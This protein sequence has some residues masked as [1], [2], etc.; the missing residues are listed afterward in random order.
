V[1]EVKPKVVISAATIAWGDCKPTFG[2]NL[3]CKLTCQNWDNWLDDGLLDAN[4]PMNYRSESSGKSSAQFRNWLKGF[5]RWNGGRPTYVG[6]DMHNNSPSGIMRQIAAVRKAGLEGYVLFSF[7][8]FPLRDSMVAALAKRN[9]DQVD[10]FEGLVS[11]EMFA[12]GVRYAAGNQLGM[13]KVYLK[14]AVELDPNY[15][16]AQYRLGRVYLRERNRE[17][18]RECFETALRIDPTHEGAKA[19]LDALESEVR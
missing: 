6:L 10:Q 19:E 15:V 2:E 13:A 17:Q 14:K 11:E 1:H 5:R 3:T 18:A 4:I 9:G 7:N 12:K 16:E 8:Q